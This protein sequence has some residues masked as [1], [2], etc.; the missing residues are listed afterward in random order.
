MNYNNHFKKVIVTGATGFIGQ[1]LVPYLLN[2]N[3]EVT[4]I[5]RDEKKAM[6]F[7]WFN[8]VNLII[9]NLK[10]NSK[11]LKIT[12]KTALIHLAWGE[13][14]DYESPFHND[15][16]FPE[17]Y[18]FI[19][20]LVNKG[21]S[22]V[23]V[24]GTCLEYG[25]QIGAIASSKKASPQ[26]PY[27]IAKDSLRA[28]LEALAKTKS[29]CLQWARLF[30]IYGKGQNIN[31]VLP[32][33]ELAIKNKKKEFN[34]S[35]GKQLRDY[36]PIEQVIKQLTEL[37]FQEKNGTYNICSGNPVS[38][39]SLVENRIKERKSKI[40]LN[41]GFYKYPYYESMKFWGIPDVGET[42]FLP[43]LPNAPFRKKSHNQQ[44]AP[45]RLRFNK[46]I[47]F[48]ENE[49]FD[50]SLINYSKNYENSQAY[51]KK[52]LAH[53][54]DVLS[55]LKS[56]MPKNSLIVEV[57][58]GMGDF[59]KMIQN[60]AY[61]KVIGYDSSYKGNNKLIQ[62]RY[63]KNTD[64]IKADLV[65]LRHVLEHIPNPFKFLTMLKKIFGNAKI[66]IEVPNYD[67]IIK[68]KTYFDITYEHVNYFSQKSLKLLFDK[69]LSE[70]G[71][72]FEKQYQFIFSELSN[73]NNNFYTLFFSSKWE[74]V[75]FDKLFPNIDHHIKDI[76]KDSVD[77]NI[78]LWGAGT[79]GCLFLS[80]CFN[81]KKLLDKVKFVVDQNK[82][83]VGK[84]L[85]GSMME[86][87]SVEEFFA[88]VNPGDLLLISNPAYKNEVLS[89]LISGGVSKI[90]LK[91]L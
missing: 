16:N 8:K 69:G 90:K 73:L 18:N 75:S 54:F 67:W 64:K 86:I 49:A 91:T 42:I 11:K 74:Y 53:M 31:S 35:E 26:I 5:V 81:R 29:F 10:D 7:E 3:Y 66:F 38:V 4:T 58:C 89:Q 36:L 39:R 24:T 63:L 46:K 52:F 57:G 45:V 33:L 1:H 87:K 34:M 77:C 55:L 20:D 28:K 50:S 88:T 65:V 9:S 14:E 32:Q 40:K 71:L 47:G 79:K 44:N 84:Y 25:K 68:H 6:K 37:L 85:P 80:H 48:L 70:H 21:I 76:E 62:K 15:K 22:Q 13:L 41:L 83:K 60:D 43:T 51:S 17:S 2:M 23:L 59:V 72:I 19:K 12:S 82:N 61:F 78:F 27:A 56:R 30:Y